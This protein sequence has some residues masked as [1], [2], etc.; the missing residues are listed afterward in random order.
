MMTVLLG[1]VG[2]SLVV[3][4]HEFGHFIIAR[5]VGVEVEAFSIGW[6]P[7]IFVKSGKK[8]EFRISILPIGGY[9]KLKGED[10]FR[11]AI[12]QKLD[13]IPASEGS[14]YS[15]HPVKRIAIAI[16]GP[17]FNI[18][19][20]ALVFIMVSAIGTTFQTAPNRIVLSSQ[21]SS[22]LRPGVVNPA[23]VAG[24]Q[25]GDIIQ[26]IDDQPIQDYS[27]LQQ[28]IASNPGKTLRLEIV[29]NSNPLEVSVTPQLDPNSGAGMIGVYAWID[30]VI[31]SVQDQSPAAIAALQ[32]G[33]VIIS[34][35]NTQIRN[36]VD[37][38]QV[39]KSANG[40]VSLKVNR[41]GE[42]VDLTIIAKT[43]EETGIQFKSILRTT[44]ASSI[45]EAVVSGAKETIS[46]FTLTIKSI[47]L[48]FKGV[49]VFKAVSG[50]A[51][52]TY[53]IGTTAS[54]QIKA[55]GLA[56]LVPVLSFLAFLSVGLS[57]MNLLPLPVLDGGLLLMFL[58]EI[59]RTRPL[60]PKTMYRYQFIGVAIVVLIFVVAT[61]SDIFFFVGK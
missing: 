2:L 3:I 48:L 27:D 28:I 9:C 22:L 56:G 33:D 7:A 34:A 49:N 19:F 20:A 16:A 24:L 39:L 58:I 54:E 53:L 18:L 41:N 1:L 31:D 21:T 32:P 10:G 38:M 59:I 37:F 15:A 36:T 47:G 12:E 25:S 61:M 8:T 6:G 26:E 11:A 45:P 50:P 35:N 30:P 14:F 46:T 57:I 4:V 40:P 44:K 29:R 60:S 42:L 55:D 17:L 5:L 23:D 51:R 52:I 13:A 43:L